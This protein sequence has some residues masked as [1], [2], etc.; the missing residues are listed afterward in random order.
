M[1][2]SFCTLLLV[3]GASEG[4]RGGA[5]DA[6][7]GTGADDVVRYSPSLALLETDDNDGYAPEL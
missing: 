3:E 4:G 1:S 7:N 2:T 5:L 6:G